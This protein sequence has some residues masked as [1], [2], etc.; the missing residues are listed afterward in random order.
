MAMRKIGLIDTNDFKS[1]QCKEVYASFGL[2]MYHAQCIERQ[3]AI[4]LATQHGPGPQNT[5]LVEFEQLLESLF[6][7][8]LGRLIRTYCECVQGTD[9]LEV[10]LGEALKKRNWLA[11]HYFWERA[12]HFMTS[13]G[14]AFMVEE[15][16]TMAAEFEDLDER[17]T[18]MSREWMQ[19]IK[20]PNAILEFEAK[21]LIRDSELM[22]DGQDDNL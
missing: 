9:S 4:V 16:R 15:L 22:M 10:E 21:R 13:R 19:R 5:P 12:G 7:K 1:E 3:L 20:M 17:L 2:A 6:G 11:H 18:A 14:R 8:T